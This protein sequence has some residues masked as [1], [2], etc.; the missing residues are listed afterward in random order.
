MKQSLHVLI[1]EDDPSSAALLAKY[2]TAT[3]Y[4]T[5]I[6]TDGRD[7]VT[8]TVQIEPDIILLDVEMPERDGWQ[9]LQE[10]RSISDVP[11]IMVTVRSDT[12]DKV[13]G[14]QEGADDYVT[15]PFDLKEI[16]ARIG[17]VLRR[18]HSKRESSQRDVIHVGQLTI[19][20]RTKIISLGSEQLQLSPKEYTL[21]RLLCSE[22]NTVFETETISQTVWPEREDATAEDVKTYVYLLR[23]KLAEASERTQIPAPTIE[24]VR[25]FGYTIRPS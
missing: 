25:G 21:L 20:H 15:K 5:T 12:A 1:A 4:Q 19:D 13:R 14:L 8:K 6:A 3:G 2:L 22:P 9:A 18:R 7:V 10:I 17:A 24:N 23:N 11:V 16:E